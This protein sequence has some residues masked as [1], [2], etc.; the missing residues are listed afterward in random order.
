MVDKLQLH[1]L[2]DTLPIKKPHKKHRKLYFL[3]FCWADFRVGI[4]AR[5]SF[6]C[7]FLSIH[8]ALFYLVMI[9]DERYGFNQL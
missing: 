2:V 7:E 5:G 9:Q 8:N 1:S 6:F 4:W 3:K